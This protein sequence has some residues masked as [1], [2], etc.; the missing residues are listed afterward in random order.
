MKHGN[1][2]LTA[3]Q[4][5]NSI[6]QLAVQGKLVPQ[7]PHDEGASVLLE[8]I[9]N[10]KQMLVKSGK[11]KKERALK[12]I[13][14][15]EIPFDIPASWEWVRLGEIGEIVGGGTPKTEKS[16][17]W[18]NGKIPWLTPADMKNIKGKYVS[19]GERHITEQGLQNSSAR[20]ISKNSLIYSSRAPIGYIAIATNELC[21]N[22]GF[23]SIVLF[24]E[25]I[26]DYLY[27]CVIQRTPE[28]KSRASGTTFKEISGT[29][30]G[31]IF[32]PFPPLAEQKRIV[33]KMEEL[34]P[35]VNVYDKAEQKLAVL[36]AAF[37]DLLKKAVLQDAIQGKLM[38]QTLSDEPASVL[39]EKIRKEKQSFVKSGKIKKEKPLKP[40]TNE[41]IPF[42][43][44]A[45]WEWVRLG[46]IVDINPR[47][48]A[49]DDTI[50][51]FVPMNLISDGY[52]NK[53]T[54]EI[55]KWQDIK[56]GFTHFCDGDIAIAKITPCFQNR[57]SAVFENLQ[58]G[59]GAG[60]TELHILRPYSNY[61]NVLYLF[62][63]CK[64][65]YFIQNGV[66]TFTGT[67][68]Q[69]RI[70][71]PYIANCLFPLPPLPEQKRIVVKIDDL[72]ALIE[73]QL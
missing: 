11:I 13:E 8:K 61:S 33:A 44:P 46:E 56:S 70:G 54:C 71:L 30:F 67:A 47:N 31:K 72:F 4:L 2:R 40:I 6:L 63:F 68:G 16:E 73:R 42:D 1:V 10:E 45:S 58:N 55:K 15:E 28:I 20:L 22:Q 39:L 5:R 60:T 18:D 26:V 69:Q 19:R 3:Q 7:D 64:T 36:N 49:D 25:S 65:V 24:D 29:E 9:R 57:K 51:S 50:T 34:M 35:L 62:W 43:I 52:Q 27:Y 38:P 66:K 23:K 48:T 14:D 41:E 21:T 12:P 37:P 59:I 53:F 32:V 17:Y